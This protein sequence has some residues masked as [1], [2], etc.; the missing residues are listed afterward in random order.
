MEAQKAKR[1]IQKDGRF[2]FQLELAPV[3]QERLDKLVEDTESPSRA[4]TI[5]RALGF[6]Y[7]LV[8]ESKAGNEI[9]IVSRDGKRRTI[10]VLE[11]T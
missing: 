7:L 10:I 3:V 1:E 8:S 11:A 2:R 6:Y 4:E 5:R 9:E